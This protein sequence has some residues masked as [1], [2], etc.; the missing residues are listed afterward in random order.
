MLREAR[1]RKGMTQSELGEAAG[2][3]R[4]TIS[5]LERDKHEARA[6]TLR[7]LADG[8]GVSVAEILEEADP[9]VPRGLV[10]LTEAQRRRLLGFVAAEEPPGTQ[11]WSDYMEFGELMAAAGERGVDAATFREW[12]FNADVLQ[13]REVLVPED[14]HL[15][16]RTDSG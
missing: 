12:F 15:Y 11:G 13:V 7:K 6:R 1:M 9:N 14:E 2:I 3:P 5:D 16:E 4:K 8:L 10:G